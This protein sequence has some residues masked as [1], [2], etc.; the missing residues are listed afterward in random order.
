MK[1]VLILGAGRVTKPAVDYLT[2]ECGYRVTMAART[3]SKAEG[4]IAGN[5]LANAVPWE[6]QKEK[7]L[8]TLVS[9]HD[10]VINMIPKAHHVIVAQCCLKHRKHM[11]TTSY[12]IPPVKA[13]DARARERGVLILNELGEDPGMDHFAAQLLLDGIRADGGEVLELH[14]YGSGLPSF[15]YNNNPMGYKFSWEPKGVFLAARVPAKYLVRGKPV[16]VEGDRLFEHFK[17][18]DIEGVGTFE[19]YPN[20]DVTRYVGPFGLPPDVTFYR[21]LLRFSGYCNNMRHFLRLDLLNDGETFDWEGKTFRD[22]AA[23]LVDAASLENVEEKTAERLGVDL[24]SDIIVRLKWLG[25][26]R[27]EPIKCERGSK[28]DVFVELL[29]KKLNYAPGETDMTIIHVDILAGFPGGR[30]EHRMVTMLAHGEPN[31]S[32]AMARAVGL[33][34]AIVVKLIFRGEITET[35]VHMPPTLP[36]L[37]KPVIS[38]M[39]RYGFEFRRQVII[40]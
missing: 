24:M 22:F 3:L 14:S 19:S 28:L 38:E 18:V 11:V 9:R 25:L 7:L 35:G 2:R 1:K 29:L 6:I 17:I 15:K 27:A 10:I 34:P 39:A 13:L 37:Y 33:P 12:E 26:F 16:A 31:G 4:I 36:H 23:Y 30:R 5:P 20:K 32:S 21:G 40:E 8:D